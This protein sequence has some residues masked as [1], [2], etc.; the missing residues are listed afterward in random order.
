MRGSRSFRRLWVSEVGDVDPG[1]DQAVGSVRSRSPA[2]SHGGLW[3]TR[4]HS[5][6]V[7]ALES[8]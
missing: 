6:L 1:A 7:T 8:R 4:A 2:T 5:S 3:T